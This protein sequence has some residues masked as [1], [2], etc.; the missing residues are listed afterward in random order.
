M[1]GT[2]HHVHTALCSS[3]LRFTWFLYVVYLDA[4][5][6]STLYVFAD[7]HKSCG[8]LAA[9]DERRITM[10]FSEAVDNCGLCR[11][12]GAKQRVVAAIPAAGARSA[13]GTVVTRAAA[14]A[15][16]PADVM[17]DGER[18]NL[19]LGQLCPRQPCSC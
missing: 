12:R 15:C 17:D 13:K 5:H 4:I 10:L 19:L 8:P 11:D 16:A 7:F 6:R 18:G 14:V 1:M 3:L 9:S 2:L